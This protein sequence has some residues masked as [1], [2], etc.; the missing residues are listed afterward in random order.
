MSTPFI[1]T[2]LWLERTWWLG[3][4]NT[5][6]RK[7]S[8]SWNRPSDIISTSWWSDD[9][10]K[11]PPCARCRAPSSICF[12]DTM[13]SIIGRLAIVLSWSNWSCARTLGPSSSVNGFSK[14]WSCLHEPAPPK[15]TI[16]NSPTS[17]LARA[18][19]MRATAS[20]A[21]EPQPFSFIDLESSTA[22]T[23]YTNTIVMSS[24]EN[25]RQ[26][27]IWPSILLNIEIALMW[28][29]VVWWTR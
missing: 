19:E 2:S 9:L 12:N 6:R 24:I 28:L 29:E 5:A 20:I 15:L 23:T 14:G 1:C 18:F 25:V 27:Q 22:R 11:L 10:A 16:P 21:N 3:L 26:G 4:T 7:L 8:F 13:S 17:N